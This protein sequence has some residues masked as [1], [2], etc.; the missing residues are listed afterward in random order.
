MQLRPGLVALVLLF[1]MAVAW[2][3]SDK[4]PRRETHVAGKSIAAWTA[5][6]EKGQPEPAVL[7]ALMQAGPEA[8]PAI[9]PLVK[10]LEGEANFTQ[11]LV[12]LTL[13]KIGPDAVPALRKAMDSRSANTRALAAR[14]LG[15]IGDSAALP[16]LLAALS[17]R[18]PSVRRVAATALGQLGNKAAV[19]SLKKLLDDT[20]EETRIEAAAA[21]WSL[22]NDSSGLVAL[23][24]ALSSKEESLRLRALQILADMG[25][26]AR[27]AREEVASCLKEEALAV[28]LQA[29]QTHYRLSGS[30]GPAL[31]VLRQALKKKD[32]R[33]DAVAALTALADDAAAAALL[34]EW[35]SDADVSI[36]REVASVGLVSKGVEDRDVA[37]RWWSAL[38][39]VQHKPA[40]AQLDELVLILREAWLSDVNKQPHAERILSVRSPT[41]ATT[42]L[43]TLVR[44]GSARLRLEAMQL[45][46]LPGLD[47]RPALDTILSQL[48]SDDKFL[49]RAAAEALAAIGPELLPRLRTLLDDNDPRVRAAAARAVAFIGVPARRLADKLLQRLQEG[50]PAE[51]IQAALAYWRVEGVSEAPLAVLDYLLKDVDLDER[52]EAVEVIGQIASEAQ[53]PIKGLTEVLVNLLK[54]RDARVR[55]MAA[56]WLWRR[57]RQSKPVVPLLRDVL[58]GRDVLARR[59]ALETLGELDEEARPTPLLVA[60]L[61][62]RDPNLRLAAIEGL[63]RVG[64]KQ[65]LLQSLSGPARTAEGARLAFARLGKGQEAAQYLSAV[66]NKDQAEQ[67]RLAGLLL[68]AQP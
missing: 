39:A 27:A 40:A 57:V 31:A 43:L 67:K 64:D 55:A 45:L 36:R 34:R 56:R 66:Q 18:D 4:K 2:P 30:S 38:H 8:K 65:A 9:A 49:R 25:A 16:S 7:R 12:V 37:V 50:E 1:G 46:A 24:V 51:C 20:D 13:A 17:D 10:H 23:R 60:A 22:G 53:P 35:A 61:Q 42:A 41:R 29:A 58:S 5:E 21:L 47:A 28:R 11:M 15:L 14:T 63:A 62:E 32:D 33:L 19:G 6:L 59:I 68:S 3:Q 44:E 48:A 52:W 26:K 54:D